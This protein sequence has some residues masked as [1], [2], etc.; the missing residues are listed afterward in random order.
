MFS[1]TTLARM[2]GVKVDSADTKAKAG[3]RWEKPKE[4]MQPFKEAKPMPV[5]ADRFRTAIS[6]ETLVLA[7]KEKGN[8][9]YAEVMPLGY[10]RRLDVWIPSA[11]F[12]ERWP[13]QAE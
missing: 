3:I 6:S 8:S 2:Y 5:S 11:E 9:T 13:R 7:I 12:V 10:A 4:R 1:N